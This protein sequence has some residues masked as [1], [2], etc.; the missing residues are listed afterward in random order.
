MTITVTALDPYN[1]TATGYGGTVHFTST[2]PAALLPRSSTLSNGTGS[3]SATLETVGGQT[4][5]AGDGSISAASGTIQVTPGPVSLSQSTITLSAETIPMGD[6]AT[7][8]LT[9]RDAYDNLETSPLIVGFGLGG[10]VGGGA[11]STVNSVGNGV[12]TAAFTAGT[13]GSNTITAS[14]NFQSVTS[15]LPSFTVPVGLSGTITT[16]RPIFTWQPVTGAA[17]YDLFVADNLSPH[18]AVIGSPTSGINITGTSFTPS[19]SQA[20]TPGHS[21]TWYLGAVGAN[22]AIAWSGPQSI[23]LAALPPPTQIGPSGTILASS[24]TTFSWDP[25]VDANHYYLYV[26]DN[27]TNQAINKP[28]VSGTSDIETLTPGQLHLVH[29]RC[30]HQ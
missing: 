30:K 1:N 10:G 25:V 20:L 7:V 18:V 2:D 19:A 13:A 5:T 22:G 15:T 16:D 26:L 9:A 23:S 3:F 24:T 17:Q 8:T 6:A 29:R 12:Y 11:F 27:T 14:I 4:I 28:N 21:Y